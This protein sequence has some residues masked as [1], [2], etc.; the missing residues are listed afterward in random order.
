MIT[1]IDAVRGLVQE[2]KL[3]VVVIFTSFK[4]TLPV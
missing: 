1:G 2:W 4:L 3:A